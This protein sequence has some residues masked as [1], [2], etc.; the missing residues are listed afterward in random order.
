MRVAL[1]LYGQPRHLL[2]GYDHIRKH[3]LE[4]YKPDVFFHTWDSKEDYRVSPWRRIDNTPLDDVTQVAHLYKP[5]KHVVEPS[6]V[7]DVD[8]NTL[9]YK[10][11]P[12][13]QKLNASNI[14]SQI[15]SRQMVRD[16]LEGETYDLVIMTRFDIGIQSLPSFTAGKILFSDQH[17]EG[18]F[19]DNFVM[20]DQRDFLRL[21]DIEKNLSR[22]T[23]Q[24]VILNMEELL[25]A[26]IRDNSMEER[27]EKNVELK[28]FLLIPDQ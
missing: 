4:K 26:S 12:D 24:G 3:I 5:V 1:C 13:S 14:L 2:Q 20:C 11:T 18:V 22:Y 23:S 8:K 21:F 25:S 9:G 27:C 6:K 10:N 15:Q 17:R 28:I 16:L 7:F 19:E